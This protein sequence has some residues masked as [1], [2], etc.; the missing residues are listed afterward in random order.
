MDYICH[1]RYYMELKSS[2]DWAIYY[3]VSGLGVEIKNPSYIV[4]ESYGWSDKNL[5]EQ[6]SKEEFS[7]RF[8]KSDVTIGLWNIDYNKLQI[9]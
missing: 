8:W 4:N 5:N 1:V 6:I 7:E 3:S 2:K 9:N